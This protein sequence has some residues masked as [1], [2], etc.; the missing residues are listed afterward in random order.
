[1]TTMTKTAKAGMENAADKFIKN[2]DNAA[3]TVFKGENAYKRLP[4]RETYEAFT[5]YERADGTRYETVIEIT[6][7]ENRVAAE[8]KANRE[9]FTEAAIG[10]A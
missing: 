9:V 8:R 1:M 5:V 10:G 7:D 6:R 3:A 4:A 2:Y